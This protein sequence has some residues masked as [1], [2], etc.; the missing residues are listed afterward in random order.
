[1]S[2][3][4]PLSIHKAESQRLGKLEPGK[5]RYGSMS[6]T[7]SENNDSSQSIFIVHGSNPMC[8]PPQVTGLVFGPG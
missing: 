4:L 1:M 6:W 7:K 5:V 3:M 8:N 2:S